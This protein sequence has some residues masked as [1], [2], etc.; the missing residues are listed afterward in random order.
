MTDIIHGNI[1]CI[2]SVLMENIMKKL[3]AII[4]VAAIFMATACSSNNVNDKETKIEVLAKPEITQVSTENESLESN[5]EEE[6]ELINGYQKV[7][8]G[9]DEIYLPYIKESEQI[10]GVQYLYD[11]Y[12]WI[13]TPSVYRKINKPDG[14]SIVREGTQG[15]YCCAGAWP[16]F[17]NISEEWE[18]S[19]I[20][21]LKIRLAEAYAEGN[22][23]SYD[24]QAVSFALYENFYDKVPGVTLD[25]YGVKSDTWNKTELENNGYEGCDKVASKRI[26]KTGV[27]YID[28]SSYNNNGKY[29]QFI[30]RVEFDEMPLDY[31]FVIND[32]MH[33]KIENMDSYEAWKENNKEWLIN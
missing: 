27:Y 9:K 18:Q 5:T 17:A 33:Y 3:L 16:D 24:L 30:T 1:P 12:F 23:N 8:I 11:A 19:K 13:E 10:R 6:V 32:D 28:Y 26:T 20:D 4:L 31:A 25:V 29:N 21:L 2:I 14:A 7:F 22:S 15:L